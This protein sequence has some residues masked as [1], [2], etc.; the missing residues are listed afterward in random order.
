MSE[1]IEWSFKNNHSVND[2]IHYLDDLFTVGKSGTRV[3]E[4]DME[5]MVALCQQL[6]APL[7]EEK[8]EGPTVCIKLD[9]ISIV[10]RLPDDRTSE[11]QDTL[12]IIRG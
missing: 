3:C 9:S 2:V 7:K 5:K 11:L 12:F 8:I 1:A 4:Q 6:G 10:A